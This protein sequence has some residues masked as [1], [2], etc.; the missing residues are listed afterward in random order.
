MVTRILLISAIIIIT[1]VM[2][3]SDG[4]SAELSMKSVLGNDSKLSM[5]NPNKM[6]KRV[7]EPMEFQF[8]GD[9]L[10]HPD[11]KT[12]WW[13]FSG[14]VNTSVN[15]EIE[16]AFAYQFTLFRFALEPEVEQKKDSLW[17]TNTIYMAHLA[18]TDLNQKQYYQQERFS[19][20]ALGLA[21]ASQNNDGTLQ[22]WLNHWQAKSLYPEQL[23]PLK[24]KLKGNK[25]ALDFQLDAVKPVVLQGENG[26]SQKSQQAGNASYYYSYTRLATQ[27]TITLGQHTYPVQGLS[28][29]D[30]EWS[31]S[32]LGVDQQ[33]WDWFS[34][35]LDDGS[36]LMLYQM[37]KKDGTK[38]SFSSASFVDIKGQ[39]QRLL[40]TE[41]NMWP[42]EFW[43]SPDSGI[44][45]PVKWQ[46]EVPKYK[47]SLT[48][49][50][51]VNAQEWSKK[52]DASFNYWEGAVVIEGFKDRQEISGS[53]FLE[54]T[55]Y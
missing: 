12:E 45:Y 6:F 37:R 15:D 22:F 14:N 4:F 39:S 27:G 17:R 9:H 19:R 33:G 23:L 31:T 53:G 2:T 47:L 5:S 54:M 44:R 1:I 7:L 49:Q 42:V 28:W 3:L 16:R 10:A 13:Y 8:P 11:Y 18:L 32:S 35:Q 26:F 46:I 40:A 52:K 43:R 51:V 20:E 38:D 48:V 24:L 50:A 30:R 41:F 34:L 29:L 55:G 21:G 25:F 36:D